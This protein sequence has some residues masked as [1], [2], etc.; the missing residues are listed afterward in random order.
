VHIHL[1]PICEAVRV[2]W[3]KLRFHSHHSILTSHAHMMFGLGK[4]TTLVKQPQPAAA[5]EH[6]CR[7]RPP[8]QRRRHPQQT[9]QRLEQPLLARRLC[10]H[11]AHTAAAARQVETLAVPD[12]DAAAQPAAADTAVPDAA[13]EASAEAAGPPADG[14]AEQELT[15]GAVADVEELLGVRVNVDDVG[16]P[17][18]E[19]L[20][21]WK[22][23]HTRMHVYTA[24][25]ARLAC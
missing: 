4:L 7:Q 14:A 9:S 11:A 25:F 19:Y 10:R 5:A 12:S 24:C 22:V 6:L 13:A 1:T 15:F 8:T 23:S 16:Q 17:L 3:V 2:L 21:H 20:V 18:V